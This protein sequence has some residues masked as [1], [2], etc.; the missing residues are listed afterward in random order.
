MLDKIPLHEISGVTRG[1]IALRS[2]FLDFDT[3]GDGSISRSEFE[4]VSRLRA[5]VRASACVCV[6]ACD[7]VCACVCVRVRVCV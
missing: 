4:K 6:S 7:R 1:E 3:D 5:C 2:M